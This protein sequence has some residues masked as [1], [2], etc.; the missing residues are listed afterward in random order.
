[1]SVEQYKQFQKL[2]GTTQHSSRPSGKWAR[3]SRPPSNNSRNGMAEAEQVKTCTPTRPG[4]YEVKDHGSSSML[5]AGVPVQHAW[6]GHPHGRHQGGRGPDAAAQATE[7]QVVDWH[8]RQGSEAPGRTGTSAQSAFTVKDDP[9]KWSKKD[10]A[11]VARR[12]ARG[13]TINL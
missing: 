3:A 8:P 7:K 12:V 13:E 2:S 10:R 4:Q 1:M 5:K 9:S 11:E 6:R